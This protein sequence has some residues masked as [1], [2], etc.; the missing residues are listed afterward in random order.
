MPTLCSSC[1]TASSVNGLIIA[2]IFFILSSSKFAQHLSCGGRAPDEPRH[3]QHHPPYRR[4]RRSSN[5]IN[6]GDQGDSSSTYR[7]HNLPIS[8]QA[9]HLRVCQLFGLALPSSRLK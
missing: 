2:S 8:S 7:Q 6:R 1:F 5:Q 4:D 9:R 3:R